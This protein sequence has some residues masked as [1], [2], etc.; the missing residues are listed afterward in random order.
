MS[1]QHHECPGCGKPVRSFLESLSH[2]D[3]NEPIDDLDA[4]D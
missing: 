3:A 4:E 2:C 1:W